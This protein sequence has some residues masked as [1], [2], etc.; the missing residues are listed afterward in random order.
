[1]VVLVG[2]VCDCVG[3]FGSL[4]FCV[5]FCG[6]YSFVVVLLLVFLLGFCNFEIVQNLSRDLVMIL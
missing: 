3:L 6:Y 5:I 1:M 4:F 2:V